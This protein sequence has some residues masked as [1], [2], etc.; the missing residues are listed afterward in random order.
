MHCSGNN[1]FAIS[2]GLPPQ[3][4]Y[5]DRTKQ[6]YSH[7]QEVED[8]REDSKKFLFFFLFSKIL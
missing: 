1:S 2:G 7:F 5:I 6:S 4:C 3:I 8:R